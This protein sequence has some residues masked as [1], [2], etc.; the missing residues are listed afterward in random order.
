MK[1]FASRQLSAR[2]FPLLTSENKKNT[3][4]S[5]D[6]RVKGY[7]DTMHYMAHLIKVCILAIE[8]QESCSSDYIPQPE[9][10]IAGVMELLLNMIPYEEAELLDDLYAGF[11]NPKANPEDDGLALAEMNLWLLP[12]DGIGNA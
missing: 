2:D 6:V 11:L 3:S 5:L 4:F 12:P 8:G 1:N 9:I 10:N 7:N